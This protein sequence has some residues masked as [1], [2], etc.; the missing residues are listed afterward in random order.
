MSITL[1]Y[2]AACPDCER[3]ANTTAKLDWLNRIAI[4][5]KDSPIGQVPKGEIVVVD[6]VAKK[7]FTGIYATRTIC[8]NVPAYFLYGFAL[9]IPPVRNYFA[10][11]NPGCNG[12][13]CE[14]VSD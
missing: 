6:N 10:K 8:L 9:Y 13:E 7:V 14:I 5:T 11:S 3:K 12:D 4:S 1:Y 2:N